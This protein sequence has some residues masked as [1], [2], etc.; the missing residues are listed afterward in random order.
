M[1]A[2]KEWFEKIVF[3]NNS[4]PAI[5]ATNLNGIQDN[6]N[7]GID[8][9]ISKLL[10]IGKIEIFF[11]NA[12]YSE[13]M[14]FKWQKVAEGMS[15]VGT[16]T[17]TDKNNVSK[18]FAS[19]NNEGEYEHTQTIDE[20]VKH[21][22]S[23]IVAGGGDEQPSSSNSIAS[24]SNTSDLKYSLRASDANPTLRTYFCCRKWKSI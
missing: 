17:G 10:P 15:L 14:G 4:L 8:D 3:K 19:G 11:D 7:K 5:N 16:G 1:S 22:H 20:I 23:T 2:I 21:R 24:W 6:V 13:Y 18:T 9:I 12:D